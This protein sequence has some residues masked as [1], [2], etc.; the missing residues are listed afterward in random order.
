MAAQIIRLMFVDDHYVV[1]V[2]LQALLNIEEDMKIVAEAE[3]GAEAIKL[4]AI[5]QPDVVLM[6]LK[7]PGLSG[8][9]AA[10]RIRKDFPFARIVMLT[11]FDGHEDIFRAMEAGASGYLLKNAP[12]GE[13]LAAI[14]KVHKGEQYLPARIASSLAQRGSSEALSEREIEAL[15]L[16]SKG[17]SNKEIATALEITEHTAKAHMKHILAK[18]GVEDRTGAVTLALRRGIIHLEE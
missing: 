4:F 16:A 7:M 5:H 17:R 18:L 6:D 2:G 14:R 9:E 13:F 8:I 10:A 3:D 11:T 1:R 15:R 12:R